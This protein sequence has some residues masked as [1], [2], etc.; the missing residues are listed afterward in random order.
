MSDVVD[1]LESLDEIGLYFVINECGG[2][3]WRMNHDMADGRIPEED[4][5]AIDKDIKNVQKTQQKA[6][7]LLPKFG[8]VKPT[9][10]KNEA[11]TEEY[12]KWFRWW[13]SYVKGLS[14][15]EWEELN[16]KITAKEDY[17]NY[18]PQGDWRA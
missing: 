12:W 15:E 1:N 16:R 9:Q 5:A 4:H 8:V 18:R 10:G 17:S 3:I 14:K 6:V 2:F 11:P 13:D 7:A